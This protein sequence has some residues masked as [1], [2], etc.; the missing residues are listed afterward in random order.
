[1]NILLQKTPKIKQFCLNKS[2]EFNHFSP[3]HKR[4]EQL[5]LQLFNDR[6]IHY[7]EALR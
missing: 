1:M 4:T 7:A 5:G 2:M 3:P 6:T